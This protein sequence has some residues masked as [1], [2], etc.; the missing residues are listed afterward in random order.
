M[1]KDKSVKM[2]SKTNRYFNSVRVRIK[3]LSIGTTL[4]KRRRSLALK[5]MLNSTKLYHMLSNG[6]ISIATLKISQ[7]RRS[8]SHMTSEALTAM[9]LLIHT[10]TKV[11]VDLAI[12]WD[13]SK[14]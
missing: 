14:Q 12:L 9:T 1:V 5:A 6:K 2:M 11:L 4:V 3:T 10:E 8:Q 13:S 7:M